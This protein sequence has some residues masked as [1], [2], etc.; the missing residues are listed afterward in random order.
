MDMDIIIKIESNNLIKK[1]KSINYKI[2]IKSVDGRYL[3]K[4]Y[5]LKTNRKILRTNIIKAIH[6]TYIMDYVIRYRFKKKY[7]NYVLIN[8]KK[9][10]HNNRNNYFQKKT[11]RIILVSSNFVIKIILDKINLPSKKFYQVMYARDEKNEWIIH[12]RILPKKFDKFV[13]KICNKWFNTQ[14]IPQFITNF[15]IKYK[16]I[17]QYL[18]YKPEKKPYQNFIMRG[19]LN[20]SLIPVTL[21]KKD[22]EILVKSH[23]SID[24]P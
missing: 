19:F 3:L 21:I 20:L 2:Q 5:E 11:K 8:N 14:P 24:V 22:K 15:L 1:K 10:F 17:R 16:F 18:L 7:I 12:I 23:M 6:N 13:I 4:G 9:Y